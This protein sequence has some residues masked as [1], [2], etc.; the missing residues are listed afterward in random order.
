MRVFAV[1]NLIKQLRTPK[2][3]C[4]QIYW[5]R[6]ECLQKKNNKL[7]KHRELR[8]FKKLSNCCMRK[9]FSQGETSFHIFKTDKARFYH[10]DFIFGFTVFEEQELNKT[11]GH[12]ASERESSSLTCG[13]KIHLWLI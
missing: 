3:C 11:T 7:I 12:H 10:S 4:V 6:F 5:T 9:P 2:Q 13:K 8:P 1:V